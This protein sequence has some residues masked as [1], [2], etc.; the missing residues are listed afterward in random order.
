MTLINCDASRLA[1]ASIRER[2]EEAERILR[3]AEHLSSGDRELLK[4]VYGEGR[5]VAEV[6][7]LS[8][9]NPRTLQSRVNR[10]LRH[11]ASDEF[12]FL[13]L[14]LDWLP[15]ELHPVVKRAFLEGRSIRETAKLTRRSVHRVRAD[16]DRIRGVLQTHTGR[17]HPAAKPL[18]DA[19]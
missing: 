10:L 16:R 11:L 7:R 14:H 3:L 18:L 5:S 19:I 13:C 1:E 4:Q 8:Q 2:R 12:R 17:N 15:R 6:A 9:A